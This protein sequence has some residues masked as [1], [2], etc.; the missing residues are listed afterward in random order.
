MLLGQGVEASRPPQASLSPG[1]WA[2]LVAKHRRVVD[3]AL[4]QREALALLDADESLLRTFAASPRSWVTGPR[5]RVSIGG[6]TGSS[7][8]IA[9]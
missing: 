2:E 3:W 7:P 4:P 9:G 8:L 5:E 1:E 6:P